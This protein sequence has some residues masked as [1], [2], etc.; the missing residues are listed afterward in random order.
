MPKIVP[1][2]V[3]FNAAG[4]ADA[5]ACLRSEDV[6]AVARFEQITEEFGGHVGVMQQ[7]VD[8]AHFMEKFRVSKK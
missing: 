1:V 4:I 6:E 8:A 7:I 3:A 5:L 2:A